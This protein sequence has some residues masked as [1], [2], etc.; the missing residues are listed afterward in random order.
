MFHIGIDSGGTHI[1]AEA[2]ADGELIA[3]ATAG[4]GNIALD[5]DGTKKDLL[6]VIEKIF[7]HWPVAECAGILIGIAGVATAGGQQE[8]MQAVQAKYTVPVA[9]VSDAELAMLNGLHGE[10]GITAIAG[11]GSICL[12]QINGQRLRVGGWGWR[13]GDDGSGYDIARRA[14]QVMLAARDEGQTSALELVLLEAL[15]VPDYLA[16]VARSYQLD[17]SAFAALARPVA[18]AAVYGNAAAQQVI[19]GAAQALARQIKTALTRSQLPNTA[20]IALAGSVPANNDLFFQT[21]ADR[22]KGHVFRRLTG[23]NAPGVQ[24]YQFGK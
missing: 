3:Q 14:F 17:R 24:Y 2:Y 21:I 11:T 19:Q 6:S 20:V 18:D 4:P 10:D 22:F 16:A 8:I 23:S 7:Q 5:P 13:F 15:H 9:V 1:V 12:A